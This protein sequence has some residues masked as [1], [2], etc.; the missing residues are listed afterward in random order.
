MAAGDHGYARGMRPPRLSRPDLLLGLLR[1]GYLAVELDRRQRQGAATYATRLLGRRA[2]VLGTEQ[3]VRTFYDETLVQR[4]GAMPPPFKDLLF[5]RGAVH[6]LDGLD[7][8]RRK[9]LVRELVADDASLIADIGRRLEAAGS[10]WAGRE[11][12]LFDEL[13]GLYGGAVLEWAGCGPSSSEAA[14]VPREL[15]RIVD[16]FGSADGAYLRAWEARRRTHRWLRRRVTDVRRGRRGA[17]TGSPLEALAA[18]RDLSASVAAVELGNLVRPTVA[19]AWLGAFAA[20]RLAQQPE[21]RTVLATDEVG[22]EHVAFA[23]EV[24]RTTPFVP[25]L[26][27]RALRSAVVEGV[28][29]RR[30]DRLV[31]DV[32]GLDVRASGDRGFDPDRFWR[33]TPEPFEIVP[34]GGGDVAGHRCPGESRTVQ[35]LAETVRVLARASWS[36]PAE[37]DVDLTRM[38]TRPAGGPRLQVNAMSRRTSP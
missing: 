21:W 22:A 1:D 36:T 26:A 19:V 25:V 15:A 30:G 37:P 23:H 7:H 29:V 27:G 34:Q 6:G 31:L 17:P 13:V 5:G 24:R 4:S 10:A 38:P 28:E 18:R 32:W 8:R 2:V 16:G 14:W 33:R 12:D 11:V 35:L 9:D 20:L 3:A